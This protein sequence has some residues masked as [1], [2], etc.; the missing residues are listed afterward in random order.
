MFLFCW[1]FCNTTLCSANNLGIVFDSNL[2]NV[3][4]CICWST[5]YHI[6]DIRRIRCTFPIL[7]GFVWLMPWFP[8]HCNLFLIGISKANL[9]HYTN[10]HWCHNWCQ[11]F[12]QIFFGDQVIKLEHKA[13]WCM[14]MQ[15]QPSQITFVCASAHQWRPWWAVA[16]F[17]CIGES[18]KYWKYLFLDICWL[19]NCVNGYVRQPSVQ[20]TT[21]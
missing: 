2:V 10:F 11:N 16:D 19:K 5:H 13:I 21:C 3:L 20:V 7:L 9:K 8:H 4:I 18:W 6:H 14:L 12:T 17:L 1:H 15:C